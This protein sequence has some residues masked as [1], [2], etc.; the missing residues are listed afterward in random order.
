MESNRS[1]EFAFFAVMVSSLL[2]SAFTACSADDGRVPENHLGDYVASGSGGGVPTGGAEGTAA[3]GGTG[4]NEAVGGT[5]GNAA[6][7]GTGG[8]EPAI[9]DQGLAGENPEQ[10]ID[11]IAPI[12]DTLTISGVDSDSITLAQPIFS[13]EGNPAPTVEAYVGLRGTISVAGNVVSNFT[14]GPV[15]VSL[16]G[17]QF[18]GLSSDTDYTIITVAENTEGYSVEQIDQSTG[19]DQDPCSQPY[20][21]NFEVIH[22]GSGL[23]G[24]TSWYMCFKHLGD[25]VAPNSVF[26]EVDLSEDISGTLTSG[27]VCDWVNNC[28]SSGHGREE[29]YNAANDLHRNGEKYYDT[30]VEYDNI[31]S[32]N[33]LIR[34]QRLDY[35][36]DNYLCYNAPVIL[37]IRRSIYP[38]GHYIV[39]VGYDD[40]GGSVYLADPNDF[41]WTDVFSISV[42]SFI[43]D[44]WYPGYIWYVDSGF[45]DGEWVGFKHN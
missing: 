27:K 43:Q 40:V 34:Q 3:G 11:G 29:L 21:N 39:L 15:D 37:H 25:H 14:E 30:E 20:Q 6:S 5:G 38:Y 32:D 36:K 12:L 8:S 1:S 33:D 9:G 19:S 42:A 24:P 16:G 44:Q 45:W 17:Y 23:C 4:G 22:Q 41:K 28:S 26:D 10:S 13:I 7:G 35:I 31:G 2:V 18:N